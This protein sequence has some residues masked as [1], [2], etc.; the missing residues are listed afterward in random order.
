MNKEEMKRRL[1]ENVEPKYNKQ[2]NLEEI[3]SNLTFTN[4]KEI[5]ESMVQEKQQ[6][7][8][9][10]RWITT[11]SI[12]FACVL[13]VGTNCITYLT[14]YK[15]Q[16][17]IFIDDYHKNTVSDYFKNIGYDSHSIYPIYSLFIKDKYEFSIYQGEKENQI[18]YVYFVENLNEENNTSLSIK[19]VDDNDQIMMINKDASK[20][21]IVGEMTIEDLTQ[22]SQLTID[23]YENDNFLEQRI[24]TL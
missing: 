19:I 11:L 5:M 23:I 1:E 10:F 22:G 15:K 2:K 7:T 9:R 4:E 12:I 17:I 6:Q 20:E 3:K 21:Y 24:I 8:K 13:L 18:G 14:Y 16:E